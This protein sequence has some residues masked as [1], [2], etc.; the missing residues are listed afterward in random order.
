MITASVM[1]ELI[2]NETLYRLLIPLF[3]MGVYRDAHRVGGNK[4]VPPH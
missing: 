3:R 4:K 2:L 1:K